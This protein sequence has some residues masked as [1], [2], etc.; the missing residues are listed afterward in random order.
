MAKNKKKTKNRTLTAGLSGVFVCCCIT[1]LLLHDFVLY[2]TDK[3][4]D[5]SS[6]RE[7]AGEKSAIPKLLVPRK[8]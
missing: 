7:M 1:L 8:E 5:V 4:G 6:V 3:T 2:Q